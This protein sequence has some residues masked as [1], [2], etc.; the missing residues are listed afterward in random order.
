MLI[1][2]FSVVQQ[3]ACYGKCQSFWAGLLVIGTLVFFTVGVPLIV[4]HYSDKRSKTDR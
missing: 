3:E 4:M 2:L 1:H